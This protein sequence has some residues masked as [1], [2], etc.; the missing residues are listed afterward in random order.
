MGTGD[1]PFKIICSNHYL[2]FYV[3]TAAENTVTLRV[4][5]DINNFGK[6]TL[7]K[8]R[9]LLADKCNGQL[10]YIH[11][12]GTTEGS[13][14]IHFE[15]TSA[16]RQSL[17]AAGNSNSDWLI[18]NGVLE[19]T[20]FDGVNNICIKLDAGKERN[21]LHQNHDRSQGRL[22]T[23]DGN[24]S[25]LYSPGGHS[26]VKGGI[27]LVQKFTSLGLFFRTTHC[28]Q[29][30][31]LGVQKHPKLGKKKVCFCHIDKFWKEHDRQI[32][33]NACKNAYLGSF[34]IPEKYVIRVLFV[35]QWT[36]LIPPLAIRVPPPPGCI[37][38]SNFF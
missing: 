32:K 12:L 2:P 28:T 18:D 19:V 38:N 5:G 29:V 22:P 31:R 7:E 13:I 36:S 27:R 10:I 21:S 1:K 23:N 34:F 35:S 14:V 6:I 25:T 26:N 33:K 17:L 15:V 8:F 4:Q 37:E 30:H 3:L 24:N 20:A 11:H 9:Q 16:I